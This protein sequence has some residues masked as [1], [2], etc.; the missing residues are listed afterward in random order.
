MHSPLPRWNEQAPHLTAIE[1]LERYQWSVF[2][3]DQHKSPS[4]TGGSY[5]DGTP[6]RLSWKPYQSRRAS[7]DIVLTWAQRYHPCA[8]AVITGALSGV[9][10]LDFDGS[11]GKRQ[12]DLLGLTAHVHTGS[13]GY[14]VYFKYPGQFVKTL[15]GT[16]KRELGQRWPGL[17]IRGDGGYAAFC[18]RNEQGPYRW[19]CDPILEDVNRLPYELRALLGLL[20]EP[21]EVSLSTPN[22]QEMGPHH[23][24]D[25][26]AQQLLNDALMR[27]GVEGRNNVG[28]WLACELR[29]LPL[30]ETDA[31]VIMGEYA[32]CV[33]ATN[34]KGQTEVYSEQEALVT[35]RSAYS[36]AAKARTESHAPP[37]ND[38]SQAACL[39]HFPHV[40][41]DEVL[42]CHSMGEWGDALLFAHLF[43][44]VC[45]YD[46][47]EKAWYVW[48][49]HFWKRDDI[50]RIRQFVSGKLASAYLDASALLSL[51]LSEPT[52]LLSGVDM[53]ELEHGQENQEQVKKLVKG[54]A[55]RA[56]ALR[57]LSRNN[58]IL[59]FAS[60]DERL[61]VTSEVWDTD[62]WLLGTYEGVLDLK[63]GVL[64][65][66]KP[67]DYIRTII[68]SAWRGLN[69]HAPRFMQFLQE[70]FADRHEDERSA[71]ISFL[72]RALG[73]GITGLVTEHIFLLLSGEEGRNGKDT[74]MSILQHVLGATVGAVSNDVIIANGKMNAPG[75]A[76]PHLCSLQ[77]KRIAWASETDK[78]DRFDIGQVKFLT[79]GGTIPARQL[80][81]KE[82]AFAPSHLL[83]LLTNNRPHADAKDK[84]FWE[85]ICPITFHMRFVDHPSGPYE[86]KKDGLVST[87]L[88]S[89]ASGI[90]AWLVRGC[91]E[92]QQQGLEIP[93]SVLRER[94]TY[95]EEEDILQQFV[96]DCCVV[97]PDAHVKSSALFERYKQWAEENVVKKMNGTAFGLEM[98]RTFQQR[99]NNQGSYYIGIGLS[100]VTQLSYTDTHVASGGKRDENG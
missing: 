24:W 2:P 61:A 20:H 14:H 47:H 10:V 87:A 72:Q 11:A 76:K 94:A 93:E 49:R 39:P 70:V 89:E 28:F 22:A 86:R 91:L 68:P 38:P 32:R 82:Y 71:L 59:A 66:G 1:A 65:V 73:Y 67:Q 23:Q 29:D 54:L 92:W 90:L 97:A 5:P 40:R 55:T 31:R 27:S 19:L 78:G 48:Q 51:R 46:H 85:R 41:L 53:P 52:S 62:S 6:K 69:E 15:N 13:G 12:L 83:V 37:A 3:L 21:Q 81:G 80:Y 25:L 26:R 50:G 30:A 79:G 64:R 100:A 75:A 42:R 95:R 57:S 60:T 7:K 77:G 4:Q 45:V 98:K 9:I 8:W 44:H 43:E 18:G 99:R 74:L 84:A 63:T 96:A 58:N 34:A 17:D 36:R 56:F 16:S 33:P 88:K 35:L